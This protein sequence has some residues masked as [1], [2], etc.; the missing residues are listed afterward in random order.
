MPYKSKQHLIYETGG[1]DLWYVERTGGDNYFAVA[2]GTDAA[3]EK[4]LYATPGDLLI[5]AQ[6]FL[7]L[8][9]EISGLPS[10][11]HAIVEGEQDASS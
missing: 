9:H 4:T 1:G 11:R 5:L 8:Y 10:Q 2:S 7:E 3:W 6:T